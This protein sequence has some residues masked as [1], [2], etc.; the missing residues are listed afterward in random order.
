MKPAL[1]ATSTAV[2]VAEV[3]LFDFDET[4]IRPNSLGLLFRVSSGRRMLWHLVAPL[5][6]DP[7]SYRLGVRLAIKRRL[8]RLCLKGR[9]DEW[10][11]EAG[12]ASAERLPVNP[13]AVAALETLAAEGLGVWLA[14][15]SPRAFVEGAVAA[16]GWP[17][18]RVVGTELSMAGGGFSGELVDECAGQ[19]KVEQIVAA[20]D[21]A[22]PRY[23]VRVAYGN[24][25]VD[26]PML[27]LAERGYSVNRGRVA[28][29]HDRR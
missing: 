27:E 20:L 26:G 7:G 8:Y 9:T 2:G 25:P 13:D 18:A 22:Y 4:L 16:F 12:M 28:P 24:L 17:V 1:G 10:L 14:T 21:G 3:A 29:V 5:V 23:V 11:R 19:S 15:A 6:I